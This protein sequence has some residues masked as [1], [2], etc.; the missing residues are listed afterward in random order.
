MSSVR[1]P[2]TKDKIPVI[3]EEEILLSTPAADPVYGEWKFLMTKAM[4]NV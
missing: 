2:D 4:K 1:M 3:C